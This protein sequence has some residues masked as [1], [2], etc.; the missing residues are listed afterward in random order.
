MRL[1]IRWKLAG[2][3]FIV[4]IAILTG[5]NLFV[6]RTLEQGY[7][8]TRRATFLG[9]ANIIASTGG[10]TV[11]RADR[12]AYHLAR[13]FS[14]QMG[15]RILIVDSKGRVIVDSFDEARLKGSLLRH[16]EVQA[17][18]KGR[19][20]AAAHVLTD[21]ERVLYAAVPVTGEDGASGAVVVVA[22]LGDVYAALNQIRGR[23]AVVSVGSGLLAAILSLI[24]AGLLTK[25]INELRRAAQRMAGGRLGSLVPV[26]RGDEIG[27]LGAAFNNM[28]TEL[29][30]L[31]RVRREF[32]SNASHELKSP[33]SSIKAL[34]QSLIDGREEDV[35]VYREFLRDI[36]TEVDRLTRLVNDMLEMARLE[37]DTR[38]LS[39]KEENIRG[40][41]EHVGA[42]L[43]A[44]ALNRGITIRIWADRE[45]KWP[46][47][48]D[49]LTLVLVNLMDNALRYTPPG[50]EVAITAGVDAKNL[51]VTVRDTGVGIAREDL[52]QV[53]D[54]FYR[55]DRARSRETGGTGLGLAI[56]KRAV[57]R[58]GG[59]IVPDSTPGK[60]TT[61]TINL[62]GV[63][64]P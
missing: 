21:G 49:L 44:R 2:T 39:R 1:S 36:D 11:L 37:G 5:T 14:D 59:G 13:R 15:A 64:I 57:E 19:S 63:T 28:S 27:E 17:A 24:L 30:R 60:G 46:V 56:V 26:R 7:L 38:P 42:I 25:P 40:L 9:D 62:P 41:I 10:N 18:L 3:Y 34:S 54:R 43:G 31:D 48:A 35:T 50:G 55:V 23:M 32:L 51:T 29:A 33:L 58:M 16:S 61:F 53:F 20:A 47:N 4:I 12:N 22:G 52:P 8:Q 45:L 6:L